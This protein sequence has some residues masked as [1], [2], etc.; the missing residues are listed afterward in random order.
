MS[1]NG[2]ELLLWILRINNYVTAMSHLF[3]DIAERKIYECIM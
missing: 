2:L 1:M 3:N